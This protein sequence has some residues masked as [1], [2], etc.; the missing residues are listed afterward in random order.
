MSKYFLSIA[1]CGILLSCG[2]ARAEMVAA[3]TFDSDFTADAGGAAFDLTANNG[4]TAG[5]S[6]GKFG[7][8]ANFERANGEFAFTDGNVLTQGGD[9]SYSAWYKSN[10]T[11]IT[12]GDRYFVLETTAGN[13]P[14]G[15]AAWAA[16]YGLRDSGGDIGQVFTRLDNGSSASL[17]IPG[18]NGNN[19]DPEWHNIIVTYDG[20]G[21]AAAGDGM[22][23]VYL[24]GSLFGTFDNVDPLESV[25]GL[26]I[27][28]H[29]AG[30]GRNFDGSIDDV[31]FYDH[32]LSTGEVTA[33][34]SASAVPEPN[35][36][37]LAMVA[38]AGLVNGCRRRTEK[39]ARR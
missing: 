17:D 27:G 29:R 34:Q 18:G 3:W 13:A 32:I 24:D 16:S 14:S 6:G 37:A 11:D 36:L 30:T 28:G 20:D 35:T 31:A 8:A 38:L 25:E 15:D 22:H 21:G 23:T 39:R 2:Q 1:A 5:E 10:V 19:G 9:H 33:L 26:V 4:A 12:G 7:N